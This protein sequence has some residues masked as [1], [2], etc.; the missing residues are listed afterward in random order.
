MVTLVFISCKSSSNSETHALNKTDTIDNARISNSHEEYFLDS[1]LNF[2]NWDSLKSYVKKKER[3]FYFTKFFDDLELNS[4][5]SD[6]AKILKKEFGIARAHFYFKFIKK[7]PKTNLSVSHLGTLSP[8]ATNITTQE[9]REVYNTFPA[10]IRNN[11]IGKKALI[12]INTYT[13]EKNIGKKLSDFNTLNTWDI[14]ENIHQLGSIINSGKRYTI[15]VFGA[16]WC[17]PCRVQERGL[18]K[19]QHKLDTSN[20]AI[21]GLSVDADKTKFA[22]YV[23]DEDF[24][25]DTYRLDDRMENPL[26]KFLGF[27]GIPRNFLLD[28]NHSILKEDLDVFEI[29]KVIGKKS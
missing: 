14:T 10:E 25:W 29:L 15:L 28:S 17:S 4:D 7:L 11:D 3:T 26:V 12:T 13:Y 22:N 9:R 19:M 8:Y 20:I 2:E 5:H 18:K 21:V 27:S 24:F 6:S 23:K 1:S 16:S